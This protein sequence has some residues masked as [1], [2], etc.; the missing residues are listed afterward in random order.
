[1]SHGEADS[2][3]SAVMPASNSVGASV[4]RPHGSTP[5][6]WNSREYFPDGLVAA[7]EVRRT[8]EEDGMTACCVSPQAF[9]TPEIW[10]GQDPGAAL[11]CSSGSMPARDSV[12]PLHRPV[13]IKSIH[14]ALTGFNISADVPLQL[15]LGQRP[16]ND[17]PFR[18]VGNDT[19]TATIA[20]DQL[21]LPHPPLAPP[22]QPP[23][24]HTLLPPPPPS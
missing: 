19:D 4:S 10:T 16:V 15:R 9:K 24:S 20:K 12:V 5:A 1:M 22:H 23:T 18:L 21:T 13:L 2:C 17:L 11:F 3:S 8:T 7:L 14:Y 6:L